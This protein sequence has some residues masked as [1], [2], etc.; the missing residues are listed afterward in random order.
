TL[1]RSVVPQRGDG[2]DERIAAAFEDTAG[3][4]PC[5]L[6]GMDTPQLAADPSPLA[7]ALAPD[8]WR[9]C[10]AWFGPAVD[11]GFWALGLARPEPALVRGVPMSTASTGAA[12]RARLTGAGLR[13]RDLPRLLD[14]DA[15]DDA[16][17]VAVLAPHGRFAAQ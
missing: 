2:L 17:R 13:V 1:F 15:A 8:A 9:E 7:P 16:A 10:D 12:Q 6:I 3:T 4:G 5:L 14:V 11:G